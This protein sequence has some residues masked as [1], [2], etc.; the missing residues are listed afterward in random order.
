MDEVAAPQPLLATPPEPIQLGAMSFFISVMTLVPY[1]YGGLASDGAQM[2]QLLRGGPGVEQ[3][4]A[5]QLLLAALVNGV[6]PRDLD[7]ALMTQAL[8]TGNPTD[9]ALRL[10]D[11]ASDIG[12]ATAEREWLMELREAAVAAEGSV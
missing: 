3:Q 7:E 6:R 11:R 5:T 10:L 4:L 2:L 1:R 9:D 12:G 8:A